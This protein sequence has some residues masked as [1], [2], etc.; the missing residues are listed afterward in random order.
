LLPERSSDLE[1]AYGHTFW[2]DTSVNVVAY[3]S[4]VKDQLFSAVFPISAYALANPT[5]AGELG[6]F[7]TKINSAC[8]TSYTAATVPAVL[9]LSGVF[10][11]SSALYRG[12]ELTGRVR[13]TPQVRLDY[14]YDIQSS[15]QFGEPVSALMNNPFLLNGG[16]IVGIPVHKGSL[17]ADYT[18]HGFEGQLQGYYI[19]ENNTL[20]RPAYSF[21]NA[22][23]S[24]TLGKNVTATLSSENVFNQNSQIYGYFGEQLPNPEN[25]YQTGLQDPVDQAVNVGF[26]TQAELL[27][28]E[29]RLVTLSV[30]FKI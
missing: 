25:Q 23:V 28:L 29:P 4:S 24:R 3:T 15:Q 17:A 6:G 18:S 27:G 14:D 20:N 10:N 16:Q 11:A 22:F 5:I 9:G 26:A 19:G 12:V 30:A 8:G 7:A 2:S 21:F 1:G 13:V